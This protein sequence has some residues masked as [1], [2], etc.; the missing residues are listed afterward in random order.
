MPSSEHSPKGWGGRESGE[1]ET[2]D[3]GWALPLD[4][5]SST[6]EDRAKPVEGLEV[7]CRVMC[8]RSSGWDPGH[9]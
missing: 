6:G 2:H 7:W 8:V 4:P 9:E 3:C 1:R 5:C